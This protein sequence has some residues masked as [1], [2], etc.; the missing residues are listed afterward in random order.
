MSLFDDAET[1]PR[2]AAGS[3]HLVRG[4]AV[5]VC[6]LVALIL[7]LGPAGHGLLAAPPKAHHP[8]HHP[9]TPI[10]R[11]ATRVQVANGTTKQGTGASVHD[12][13][14][15][16]GWDVLPAESAAV[17]IAHTVV[18][19]A[20]GHQLA[21]QEIAITLHVPHQHVVLRPSSTGVAGANQDDV[22]VILGTSNR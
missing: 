3:V 9:T 18:Y 15:G 22:I 21:A 6:F 14:F 11:A 12:Q 13:L 2:A 17:R 5:V 1:A 20:H 7:L 16:L 8:T 4:G 19:F 10:I